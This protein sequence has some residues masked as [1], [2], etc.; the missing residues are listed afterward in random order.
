VSVAPSLISPNADG[1]ADLARISY[2]IHAPSTVSIY[3]TDANGQ[4]YD[5]RRDALRPAI[6][7]PYEVLFNG[8]AND[9]RMLPNGDY[10]WTVEARA[11]D[12]RISTQSGQLTIQNAD[13]TFPKIQ[14][15]TVSTNTFTPNRDSIED[16]VYINVVTTKPSRLSVYV[17][18]PNG[19]RFDIPRQETALSEQPA[20]GI[21]PAGRY[22]YNYDGGINL[23]ADPPED[24]DY[25]L[26]AESSDLIGQRDTLT[27]PLTIKDSGRPTAEIMTQPNG[28]G[29]E[30]S[31][32]GNG[33]EATLKL[34]DT[35]YFTTT[36]K[37]VGNTPIR[38]GGPF[39]PDACYSM[40]TNRYTKGF[41]EEPGVWRVGVDYETNTGEDHPWR[42]AVGTLDELDEVE[43]NG[44]TLYYLAPGKQV[45]VRGCIVLDK[46]PKRNPFRVWG[47][48]IQEQVEIAP[49]NSRVTP[50][51]VQL[52][53]P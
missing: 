14:D 15:F 25:M 33:T 50:I 34:G 23:G 37:N 26:V 44:D 21:L 1:S 52:V 45:Q 29:F 30:W 5:V 40:E 41:A 12:G 42:W 4:R 18:G 24:G 6:P 22:F 10:T 13:A 19:F 2:R 32:V 35:L 48:L 43:H 16:E 36:I 49:I 38:T 51:L 53:E 7:Q 31:G 3:L 11:Q 9:G 8:I 46:I 20:D 47:A 17:L 28:S 39:D 27:Q